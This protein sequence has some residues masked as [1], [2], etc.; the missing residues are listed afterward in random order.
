M[1]LEFGGMLEIELVDVG[2]GLTLE[3]AYCWSWGGCVGVGAVVE[4]GACVVVGRWGL[5]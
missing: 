4:T 5:L 1:V 2:M 3:W